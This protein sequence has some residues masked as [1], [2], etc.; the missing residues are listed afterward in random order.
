[1]GKNSIKNSDKVEFQLLLRRSRDG[2]DCSE[3]GGYNP[4][5]WNLSD[6]YFA[7]FANSDICEQDEYISSSGSC[8]LLQKKKSLPYSGRTILMS[9]WS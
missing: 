9:L 3:I 7:L 1:M 5:S 8:A 2:I 6:T 4:L